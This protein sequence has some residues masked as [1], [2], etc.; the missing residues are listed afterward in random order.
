MTKIAK[1]LSNPRSF[2]ATSTKFSIHL[3]RF[4]CS[5]DDSLF[6]HY[7]KRDIFPDYKKLI[8]KQITL[9]VYMIKLLQ[10][11]EK[12]QEGSRIS[13]WYSVIRYKKAFWHFSF[14]SKMEF[15]F[16]RTEI[17]WNTQNW[18]FEKYTLFLSFLQA[19]QC[20]MFRVFEKNHTFTLQIQI[21]IFENNF[22]KNTF[23]PCHTEHFHIIQFII[24]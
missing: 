23:N 2:E 21:T 9:C 5:F 12:T 15:S 17:E 20:D 3:S 18:S 14:F 24:A 7:E 19:L 6:F 4:L 16:R 22:W 11:D 13:L 8:I 10:F 1:S